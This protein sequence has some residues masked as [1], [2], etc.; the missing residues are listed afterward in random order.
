MKPHNNVYS[1]PVVRFSQWRRV[2]ETGGICPRAPAEGTPKG[3][4]II[5]CDTKYTK[6][7]WALLMRQGWAWKDKS[8][9]WNNAHFRF[10]SSVSRSSKCIKIFGGWGFAPDPTGSLQRSPDPLPGFARVAI[11]NLLLLRGGNGRRWECKR[12]EERKGCQ[13]DLCPE[14]QKPSR[15]LYS[16]DL[17]SWVYAHVSDF[18]YHWSKYNYC[19]IALLLPGPHIV[20][21]LCLNCF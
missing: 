9:A 2:G 20:I 4:S 21:R 13:N 18:F 10:I 7:L 3:G 19:Y 8:C 1:S 12:G 17:T 14:R 11:S 16:V 5:F 6:I 15:R